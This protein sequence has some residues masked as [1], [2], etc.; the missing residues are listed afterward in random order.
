MHIVPAT[1]RKSG[2]TL[3]E[4]LVVIAI[5]AI[6]AAILFPV[7]ARARENARKASCSSNMKQLGLGFIQYLQDF[8][9]RYPKAGNWQVWGNGGHWVAGTS[10][11][12]V[13]GAGGA[14]ADFTPPYA[15]RANMKARP[16]DGAI[17]PYIKSAQV[18]TC[19]S[20][21]DGQTTGLSY[22]MNCALS[23]KAEFVVQS[24][25][26]VVLLVDEAYPSDGYFWVSN[27]PDASDQLTSIH[28]GGGNLLFA[29][30]HAKFYPF[31]RFP[32]GDN[33]AAISGNAGHKAAKIRTSGQP[34]FLEPEL[35]TL[36]NAGI[37][38]SC[39]FN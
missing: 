36:D 21:R 33:G 5:I 31:A 25:T 32:I 38:D 34:R 2:F 35:L 10:S 12:A 27:S 18:Y 30:G 22:S 13:D 8:D 14:L 4:L 24:S 37:S 17:Y 11:S 29:D 28:N 9:E 3:I 23:S 7:F 26:E 39:T 19:P 6:L 15:A 16:A 20:S 1:R